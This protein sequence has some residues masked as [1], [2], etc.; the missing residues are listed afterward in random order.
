MTFGIDEDQSGRGWMRI[1]RRV[2]SRYGAERLFPDVPCTFR[3]NG[4]AHGEPLVKASVEQLAG[5]DP[6]TAEHAY[7]RAWFGSETALTAMLDVLGF[8]SFDIQGVLA[9]LHSHRVQ[10]AGSPLRQI[11]CNPLGFANWSNG[12]MRHVP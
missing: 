7:R 11:N 12:R 4:Q 8:A 3:A 2:T 5:Y 9:A 6:S 1:R 10:T